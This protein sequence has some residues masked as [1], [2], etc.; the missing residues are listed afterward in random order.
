MTIQDFLR[1]HSSHSCRFT[2]YFYQNIC[3]RNIYC[4]SLI[5]FSSAR[6]KYTHISPYIQKKIQFWFR[7][8]LN[9]NISILG[10]FAVMFRFFAI[11]SGVKEITSSL[12]YGTISIIF[13]IHHIL[14]T[15]TSILR[16]VVALFLYFEP[17]SGATACSFKLSYRKIAVLFVFAP[18]ILLKYIYYCKSSSTF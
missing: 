2:V 3:S 12:S 13:V 8:I 4:S 6:N 1:I 7:R 15:Y 14:D 9:L 5:I 10:R 18:Y 16:S 17:V 11:E